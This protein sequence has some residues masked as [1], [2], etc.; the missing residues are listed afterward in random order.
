MEE[1]LEVL[2]D[3]A[4]KE[5]ASANK[6]ADLMNVKAK[7]LGKSSELALLLSKLKD[8]SVEDKKKYGSL[9]NITKKDLEL[10]I[11][12]RLGVLSNVS[13][14][15]DETIPA[16]LNVGTLHPITIVA[17]EVT[18]ILK[19]L[20]FTVVSGPEME[21][22]YYNFE[23]LNIPATHPARDMQDTYWLSN[24]KLL[25]THTSPMQVR[26]MQ[27]YGAPIK[28]CA[29]GRCFRN[30][31]LDACHENTFFQIEGM[32]I[33][34]N[35]SINN[36]IF[37]MKEL[38]K[39]VFNTDVE[40]RLRPG[41]FPFVEPGFELDCSCLICGGKGCPTCKNSGWLE[42]CPCGMIHPNV[43]KESKIDPEKYSGFAFGLGLTRL[44]MMKY[45]IN[46]IRV[47]NSGDL[48]Y[49]KE[50]TD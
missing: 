2:I 1:K 32:V 23:A 12:N 21:S 6:E 11:E 15:F 35:V 46:D 26:A 41:F 24:G 27:K 3:N 28:M 48:R 5:I 13:I 17:N 43:L 37:V 20:G 10:E 16:S 45:K 29:P 8:M 49:L 7:Y 19:R 18:S 39:N 4:K 9:L 40:V 38:L 22:E 25:R 44:A 14:D 50:F 47:L 31:D 34:E 33:D 36:L 42:L 30:E